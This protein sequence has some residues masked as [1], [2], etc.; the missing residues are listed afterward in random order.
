MFENLNSSVLLARK[1]PIN[2]FRPCTHKF[3]KN[4]TRVKLSMG[5]WQLTHPDEMSTAK[6]RSSVF[7]CCN[8]RLM[9]S[10]TVPGRGKQWIAPNKY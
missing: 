7:A 4:K 9:L 2:Q 5:N 6:A 8:D 10:R 1:Q 3:K